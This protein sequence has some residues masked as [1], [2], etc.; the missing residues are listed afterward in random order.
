M[1]KWLV[2]LENSLLAGCKTIVIGYSLRRDK[3]D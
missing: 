2:D 3:D 1:S